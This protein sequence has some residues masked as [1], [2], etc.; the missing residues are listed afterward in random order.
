MAAYYHAGPAQHRLDLGHTVPI[1]E[2]WLPGS[3][4][5]RLLVSLPYWYGPELETCTWDGGHARLLSLLP[6]TESELAYKH[7]RGLEELERRFEAASINV[8]DPARAAVV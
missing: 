6:I 2:P 3:Q 7:A 5:D 1:G 4:C 8:A